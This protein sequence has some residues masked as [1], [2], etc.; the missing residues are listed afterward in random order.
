MNLGVSTPVQVRILIVC[1]S[2]SEMC[3]VVEGFKDVSR[4]TNKT[5]AVLNG[6]RMLS[7]NQMAE[8]ILREDLAVKKQGT[9]W[10][11]IGLGSETLSR[12][13]AFL[14]SKGETYNAET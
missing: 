14:K 8:V 1:D 12:L 10:D 13:E 5:L 2:V 4:M 7:G 6:T 3:K 11:R 9:H